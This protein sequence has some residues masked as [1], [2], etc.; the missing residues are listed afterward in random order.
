MGVGVGVSVGVGVDVG[1]GVGV[2]A[3]VGVGVCTGDGVCFGVELPPPQPL[4]CIAKKI[5]EII[6]QVF[7]LLT[8]KQ[9]LLV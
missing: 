5:A 7:R 9:F 3:C 2:G 6:R 1:I 4:N 8:N